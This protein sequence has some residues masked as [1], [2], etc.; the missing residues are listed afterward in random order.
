MPPQAKRVCA[1]GGVTI[2]GDW[3]RAIDVRPTAL[4]PGV[5]SATTRRAR[6]C[7]H[8]LAGNILPSAGNTSDGP[9]VS[10][11]PYVHG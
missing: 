2:S 8:R 1:A 4:N 3:L 5:C 9:S 7:V 10:R 11:A 6:A